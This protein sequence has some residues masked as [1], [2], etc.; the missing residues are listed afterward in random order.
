[1]EGKE[2]LRVVIVILLIIASVLFTSI[3]IKYD[4]SKRYNNLDQ[5]WQNRY[6]SLENE[7]DNLTNLYSNMVDQY[8]DLSN[9]YTD[10]MTQYNEL[11][12]EYGIVSEVLE[13]YARFPIDHLMIMTYSEIRKQVQPEYTP[14]YG[15]YN[16]DQKSM[17][18]A[19]LV[20]AHDLARRYWPDIE[21]VYYNIKGTHLYDDAYQK[22]IEALDMIGISAA[23]TNTDKIEKILQFTT[24]N[25]EYQSDFNNEFLFPL[26]TLTFSSGDCDDF[27]ILAATLFEAAGI[28]SAIGF[29]ENESENVAHC[30]VLVNLPD[31]VNYGY[32]YYS[33][34]TIWDLSS[35]K[36]IIL[37]PQR[38]IELQHEENI[39]EKWTITAAAEIPN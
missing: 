4:L 13:Q 17:D 30:M 35:G 18:Y 20:C 38:T 7:H 12:G 22:I 2:K 8:D 27:S 10:L 19:A 1:M 16:Y 11:E 25:I 28:E 15:S 39:V 14:W 6:S 5:D 33:D 36:W 9:N 34:L 37:E 29:F 3:V 21:N 24:S 23:D 26:E 31:L 32:W